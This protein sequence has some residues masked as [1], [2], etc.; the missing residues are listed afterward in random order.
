[1]FIHL[2][3][4]LAGVADGNDIA[5]KVFCDN[6]TGTDDN[7][8]ADRDA[9]NDDH[10]GTDPAVFADMH[11]CVVLI[12]LLPKLRRNGVAGGRYRYMGAEHRIIAHINVR[13]VNQSQIKLAYTFLP[14]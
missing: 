6:A 8:V 2:A 10:V 4:Y 11:G 14:K 9:R 12:S 5:G 13:I 3:Q 1:M 7:I